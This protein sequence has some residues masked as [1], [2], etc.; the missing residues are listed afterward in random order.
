[1][2]TLKV[3]SLKLTNEKNIKYELN[4]ITSPKSV[5]E[6][7][8]KLNI[9][10]KAQEY[11]YILGLDNSNNV[12][13]IANIGIGGISNATIDAKII[14]QYLYLSNSTKFILVHNH[15]SGSLKPSREDIFMTSTINNMANILQFQLLD[16]IIVTSDSFTSLKE[17][18]IF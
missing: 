18:K 3:K 9:T 2:T 6:I 7:M 5:F 16:H 13:C 15:P 14:F 10:E 17:N 8:Q 11:V 4:Q 1:M 12:N